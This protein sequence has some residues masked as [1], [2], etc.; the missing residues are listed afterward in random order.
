VISAGG[1]TV[2]EQRRGGCRWRKG[3]DLTSGLSRSATGK[4]GEGVARPRG[5]LGPLAAWLLVVAATWAG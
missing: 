2:A 1:A 3:V 5:R 4:K